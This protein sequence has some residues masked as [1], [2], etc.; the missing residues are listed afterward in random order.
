MRMKEELLARIKHQIRE[1]KRLK[2]Q[3]DYQ[4]LQLLCALGRLNSRIKKVENDI[5]YLA[6]LPAKIEEQEI[7][8]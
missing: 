2:R 6:E 8:V 7:K 5:F 1:K 4:K 3:L